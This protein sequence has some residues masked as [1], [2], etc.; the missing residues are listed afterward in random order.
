MSAWVG[1]RPRWRE[2][3]LRMSAVYL[4]KKNLIKKAECR[5][6]VTAGHG[7]CYLERTA[8]RGVSLVGRGRECGGKTRVDRRRWQH[9]AP[10]AEPWTYAR[11][12]RSFEHSLSGRTRTASWRGEGRSQREDTQDEGH[13]AL[14]VK[15]V[16]RPRSATTNERA[17]RKKQATEAQA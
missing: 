13:N 3:L 4:I 1:D 10:S 14:M 15:G 8:R 2:H 17:Q 9:G 7:G 12:R 11:N 6:H 16:E 5:L